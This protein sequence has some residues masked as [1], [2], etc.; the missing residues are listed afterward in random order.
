MAGGSGTRLWPVS[1]K[2]SPKQGQPF[3][4]DET[5]LQKT[6]RRLRRGWPT[7]DIF[8]ST[9]QDQYHALH[10]QLRSLPKKQFI[11]ETAKR[12]TAP[13]IGLAAAY[14][15]RRHPHEVMFTANSDAY[16]KEV[17][18][19]VRVVK[20]AGKI[21]QRYPDKTTLIGIKPRFADT[22]LGYIKLKKQVDTI[23]GHD[24][25]SVD[26]FVEKP[27]AQTAARYVADWKYLWNPAMFVFRV[28]AMLE[29]FRRWLPSSYKLL[30]R[31]ESSIGTSKEQ[32]TVKR[33][34]P[35]MQKI[36]IDY[37]IMERDKHMLVIPANLT[38]ADIGSWGA[39]YDMLVEH[40][41]HNV[42][43]GRHILHD[44]HGNLI[45]SYSGKMVAT[46]GLHNMIIVETSDAILVCPRH[47]AHDVKHVVAELERQGLTR[48][49]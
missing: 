26:R 34:F 5:L 27:D 4:D 38:W 47:R 33:L 19:Y 1:R 13:A 17:G 16:L 41:G 23:D 22:G 20:H 9:N 2:N 6:F 15:H 42:A 7:T 21:V 48:Y 30:Q 12:E 36:S 46:A 10:Q 3:G 28:D 29:K 39:I 32:S 25:F 14:L 8:V 44:S 37:A 11:L 43:K 24:V 40:D 45:F 31:I 49:L 18:A 35:K